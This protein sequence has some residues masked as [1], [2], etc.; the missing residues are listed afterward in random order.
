VL[1]PAPAQS[2]RISSNQTT[3]GLSPATCIFGRASFESKKLS[4]T[5]LVALSYRLGWAEPREQHQRGSRRARPAGRR[6]RT[7]T[8]SPGSGLFLPCYTPPLQ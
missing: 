3:S 6:P 7:Y 1:D 8:H 4:N 5:C 2:A